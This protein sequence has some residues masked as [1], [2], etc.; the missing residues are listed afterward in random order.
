MKKIWFL[1]GLLLLSLYSFAQVEELAEM[2]VHSPLFVA[3]DDGIAGNH[4]TL[5][6]FIANEINTSQYFEEGV[7]E[8]LFTVNADGSVTNVKIKNSVSETN[9]DAVKGSIEKTS[10]NWKPGLVDGSPVA[11]EKRLYVNF[12]GPDGVSL[13]EQAKG[14]MND[15]V[16]LYYS[17]LHT[18]ERFDLRDEK[19]IKKANR[20]YN[21]ALYCLKEAKKYRPQEASI[22]FW[23]A[24][25]YEKK[26]DSYNYNE[27]LEEFNEMTIVQKEHDY[28]SIDVA[29]K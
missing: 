21:R 14:Y 5:D 6:E 1:S 11:M 7:V 24:C 25:I 10:G 27:K 16:R 28:E 12:I 26:G 2:T 19:A 23:Q 22:P 3:M 20:K 8:V 9:D 13:V 4:L 18:T 29:L 15:G 17:A